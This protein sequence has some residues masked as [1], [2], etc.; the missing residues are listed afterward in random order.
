M[1]SGQSLRGRIIDDVPL[2]DMSAEAQRLNHFALGALIGW[3]RDW[4]THLSALLRSDAPI[5]RAVREQL[6]DAIDGRSG[7]GPRLSMSEHERSARWWA[8]VIDRRRWYDFGAQVAPFVADASNLPTGIEAA[9]GKLES[10]EAYCKKAYYYRRDCDAWMARARGE[11]DLYAQMDTHQLSLEFHIASVDQRKHK[12]TPM[13]GPEFDAQ[14]RDRLS[15]LGQL[16]APMKLGDWQSH[17]LLSM[18]YWIGRVPSAE[19]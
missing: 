2:D 3:E 11:G 8:S 13:P 10:S 17:T 7:F 12:P 14:A 16:I 5:G 15:A 19:D 9:A 1:I 18:L 4:Q 6:A